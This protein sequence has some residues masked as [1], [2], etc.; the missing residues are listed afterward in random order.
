MYKSQF[1]RIDP[2]DR[3][4]GPGSHLIK[5][6][7]YIIS[8]FLSFFHFFKIICIFNQI[9][10][11]LVSRRDFFQKLLLTP[12]VWMVVWPHCIISSDSNILTLMNVFD[13]PE[14]NITESNYDSFLQ[15]LNSTAPAVFQELQLKTCDL[16]T[17]LSQVCVFFFYWVLQ[18][19]QR[20]FRLVDPFCY[21]HR[22]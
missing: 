14:G 7:N 9:N 12:Y 3:F 18:V 16:Q 17:L 15:H 6:G 4:R 22:E 5:M 8:Y 21:L 2:Y 20:L 1:Q 19:S 13:L 11:V 10:A